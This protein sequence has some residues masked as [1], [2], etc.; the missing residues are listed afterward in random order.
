MAAASISPEIADKTGLG[1]GAEGG[2]KE[3]LAPNTFSEF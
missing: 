3:N 1:I 2:E